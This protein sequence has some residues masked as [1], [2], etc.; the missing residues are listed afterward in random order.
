MCEQ[1]VVKIKLWILWEV[2][3]MS[4]RVSF[5]SWSTTLTSLSLWVIHCT[6]SKK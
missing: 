2:Y 4:Y 3:K 5:Y 6:D 1:E